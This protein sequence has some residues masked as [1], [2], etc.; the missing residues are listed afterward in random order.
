MKTLLSILLGALVAMTLFNS[1]IEDGID[2]SPSAQP[3]F[4]TDTLDLGVNFTDQPTPTHRFTVHNRG[5]KILSINNITVN[6]DHREN[7]RINVD[8]FSGTEF[9]NVE[10][11]P[12]DSI[13]VF[14]EATLPPSNTPVLTDIEAMLDFTTNGVTRGVVLMAHGQDVVRHRAYTVTSDETWT[15]EYPHQIF[16]SLIVAEGAT[17]TLAPG[18]TLHFHDKAQ[19]TVKGRLSSNGTVE[20]PV[21]LTGDRTGNVVGDISFDLMA[22]Q[23]DGVVIAPGSRDNRLTHTHMRN[24]V[25]GLVADS[26]SQVT[27]VNSRL[28]NSATWPLVSRY[29][30]VTLIG[31]EV[32]EGSLGLY[33]MMGGSV[34]ANHC[35]FANYYLFTAIG[36]AALQFYHFSPDT[37]NE[38]GMPYLRA[39]IS[40]S[41]VY[42]LGQD[43]SHGDFTDT[44]V[45]LRSCVLKSAGEDDDHF[46]GCL[47]DTDPMY[48]TVREDY[49]FDYR[50]LPDSPVI[51]KADAAL[52]LP[53]AATDPY[54]LSRLP[55]PTPGAYQGI[56]EAE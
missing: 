23:W 33:A 54:G 15:A 9:H 38:S 3:V 52:T 22:S 26:L 28:R 43:L 7:F 49:F 40:N 18:T 48:A 45:Y 17:L 31:T 8:G 4:S 16:D 53:E 13:Y 35:T 32:A 46:I 37:D 50:V 12:K 1:C 51:G 6:G 30:D 47:W 14:V 5:T 25:N 34:V 27:I 39:D 44:A 24:T 36:G 56:C 20:Q 21:N 42:G 55:Q 2:T 29:A 19:L 41:I 11:R 10:I